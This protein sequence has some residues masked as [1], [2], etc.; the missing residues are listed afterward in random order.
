[1]LAPLA[2]HTPVSHTQEGHIPS[3]LQPSLTPITEVSSSS[4]LQGSPTAP[5]LEHSY[6]LLSHSF[7]ILTLETAVCHTVFLFVQTPLHV[8]MSRE[9]SLVWFEVYGF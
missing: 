6:L 3:K 5:F 7:V 9:E 2:A 1:M 4:F 8:N